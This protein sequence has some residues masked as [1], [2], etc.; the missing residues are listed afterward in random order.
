MDNKRVVLAAE[1]GNAPPLP[2]ELMESLWLKL[3]QRKPAVETLWTN[4]PGQYFLVI[5][6]PLNNGGAAVAQIKG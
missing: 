4:T 3:D 5:A 2:P 1:P 6:W